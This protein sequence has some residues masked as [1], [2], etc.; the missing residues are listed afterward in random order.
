MNDKGIN[1]KGINA[2]SRKGIFIPGI[3]VEMF[4]N[5][6]L[7]GIEELMTSGEIEDISLPSAQPEPIKVS[8][9]HEMAEEELKELKKKIAD[10]P[11]ALLPSAQPEQLTDKEQRIFLA[12]MGRE[13]EV[14]KQVDEECCREP[15]EDSL[16]RV[17]HEIIR[18]VKAALWE[19]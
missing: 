16:V 1:D 19:T 18:K 12:A 6:S 13:E 10:S 3:T 15:Y 17:C 14:C 11:V 7:E 9:D 8:V 5:A 4:R 2:P